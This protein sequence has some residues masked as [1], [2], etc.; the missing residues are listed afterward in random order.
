[1]AAGGTA[2]NAVAGERLCVA[3]QRRARARRR[4]RRA[5]AFERGRLHRAGP[6][7]PGFTPARARRQGIRRVHRGGAAPLRHHHRR[8]RSV[9][10]RPAQPDPQ[11]HPQHR[12]ADLY[13]RQGRQRPAGAGRAAGRRP[14]RGQGTG[15]DRPA[16]GD[17]RP[18]DPRCAGQQPPEF[19]TARL[20]PDLRQGAAELCRLRRQ[21]AVLLPPLQ[22]AHAQ[23]AAGDRRCARR[24]RWTQL[25][26]RLLRLGQ[27][28]Q[29]P[30]PRRAGGRAGSARDGDQLR[31]VLARPAQCPGRTPQRCRRRPAQDRRAADAGARLPQSAAA[32]AGQRRGQRPGLRQP[33]VRGYRPGG[34]LGALCRRSAAQASPRT[35]QPTDQRPARHRAAVGCADRQRADRSAAADALPGAVQAGAQAVPR[36]AQARTAAAHRG[37]HQQPGGHRQPDRLRAVLQVQTPQHARAG[38]QTFTSSSRSRWMPRSITATCCLPRWARRP[39]RTASAAA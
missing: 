9:A 15:A 34:G 10:G 39:P 6:L 11:R 14:A 18:A 26:G 32:A 31:C 3:V 23:Q 13:L 35:P 24:G 5:G 30:R 37:L 4:H 2:G 33:C 17:L 16:L 22:P 19:R 36:P 21:R 1:M 20:Q 38:L 29:L 25:P 7:R 8:R 28:I 12:P 27:R